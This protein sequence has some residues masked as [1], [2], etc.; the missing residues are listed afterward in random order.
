MAIKE[1]RSNI[2]TETVSELKKVRYPSI[3]EVG[4]EF[5]QSVGFIVFFALFFYGCNTLIS[6]L[7]SAVL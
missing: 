6:L 7:M 2:I 4:T 5:I 1:K 3:K